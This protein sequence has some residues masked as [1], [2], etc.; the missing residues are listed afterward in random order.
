M[1]VIAYKLGY[2]N[3]KNSIFF[4]PI[5]S[6]FCYNAWPIFYN[7]ADLPV[8][9]QPILVHPKI[10]GSSNVIGCEES[11]NLCT[12]LFIYCRPMM[13]YME[14]TVKSAMQCDG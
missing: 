10:G 4:Q 5:S 1:I 11:L 7:F 8:F 2:P 9:W 6:L 13:L 3:R 14:P 12:R